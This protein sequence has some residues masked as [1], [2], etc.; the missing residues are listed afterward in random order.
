MTQISQPEIHSLDKQGKKCKDSVPIRVVLQ[1]MVLE[2]ESPLNASESDTGSTKQFP[3]C[4]SLYKAMLCI[5]CGSP[6]R[7]WITNRNRVL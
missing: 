2:K 5:I 1:G 3:P 7:M 6:G 4:L